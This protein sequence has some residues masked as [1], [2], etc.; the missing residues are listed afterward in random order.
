MSASTAVL[1]AEAR[2]IG[3]NRAGVFW[4]VAFPTL[5]LI[6]LGLLPTFRAADAA[7]GGLRMVDAYVPALLLAVIMSGTQVMPGF[8]ISYREQGILRRMSTTPVRP[9]TLLTAQIVLHAVVALG[10]A[11]LVIAAGRLIH[12]VSLPRHLPGYVAA[13]VLATLAALA[14]GT[15]IAAFVPNTKLATTVATIAFFPLA[16]SAGLWGP[17]QV[18]PEI[19]R[20]IIEFTPFGAAAQAL[21]QAMRGHWPDWSLLGVT[22]LWSVVLI[23]AAARWFRWE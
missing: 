11:V 14:L 12:G 16:I 7:L 2:L 18:L 13:L 19:A 23:A 4:V 22:A 20:R 6:I 9:L 17:V 5:L 3:R 15:I 8:L 1:K 10:S 21:D